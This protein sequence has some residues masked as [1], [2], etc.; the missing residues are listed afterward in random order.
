MVKP[1]E[2][3]RSRDPE[4]EGAVGGCK[5]V[6]AQNG[7]KPKA[8]TS[9]ME[10]RREQSPLLHLD[11]FNFDCPEAEGSRYV[12]TSPRSLEACARCVVKP[13]ELLP[14]NLNDL[15]KEAPGRSMRVAAG[16]YEAYEIDRQR[17]LQ[18]CRDERERIIREEKR[19]LFSP[20]TSSLPSSPANKITLKSAA[21]GTSQSPRTK[22]HSL[23][24][25]QKRKNGTLTAS[26]SESGASSYSTDSTKQKWAQ[27]SPRTKTIDTMNSII[28]RS[29]SLGDLSHS[30]QTTKKVEK[31]VKEVKK[32]GVKELPER[33]R[34]IAALMIAKHQE[35]TILKEQRYMAHIQWDTLRQKAELRKEQEEKEKQR[36]LLQSQKMWETRISKR[37]FRVTQ[38]QMDVVTMKQK[39]CLLIEERWR[40][41][42]EKQ[43]R[44][45]RQ[46]LEQ[47]KREE[48]HKKMHQEHN[49][50]AKEEYKRETLERDVHLLCEKLTSAEQK[51]LDK[52]LQMQKEKRLLNQVEKL[53]HEAMVKEIDKQ[54]NLESEMLKKSLELSFSKAQ[55]N[56]EQL[57]E[58]RNLELKEKAKREEIQIQRARMM[59]EKKEKEQ[60]E[61]LEALAKAAEKKI[62]HAAEVAEEVVQ[63][64]VR[65]A[66]Q[67]RLEK[68]KM[69]K[70]NKQKVEQYEALKRKELLM[71]IE[72]KLER[73]EQI[74]REKKNV[75]DSA[76]SVARASFHVRD[77]VR[78]ETNVRT[79]DKMAFEAVPPWI[80]NKSCRYIS[81]EFVL[82]FIYFLSFFLSFIRKAHI[83]S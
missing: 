31:I 82:I 25:L 41:Q 70:V 5:V 67:S 15:V 12:L 11:L 32:K 81:V 47:A 55:G 48:K 43:E 1:E 29:F 24:S 73:S 4:A 22:S 79:F 78:E 59:V 30:P 42:A 71:S 68:E 20:L 51:K 74:F 27:T 63:Q 54:E 49:L 19:R 80:K 38:E 57:L 44:M 21:N 26:S 53:K 8:D 37:Q 7:V 52:E 83:G 13:V 76:R 18:L 62:Q 2:D 36:A 72:K 46:K 69:Q 58:K 45:R 39:Q 65:K 6:G 66:V 35:E 40:E 16:L 50:K 61:H 23:D 3:N 75:L 77:K 64:K 28:G 17:K 60:K 9:A 14:R 56:F 10:R 34:K 33:D